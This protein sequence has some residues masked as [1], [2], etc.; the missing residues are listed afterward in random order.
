MDAIDFFNSDEA[1]LPRSRNTDDF[2]GF[3]DGMVQ[4]YVARMAGLQSADYVTQQIA[5][6]QPAVTALRFPLVEWGWG[7][8]EC[9][10]AIRAASTARRRRRARSSTSRPAT[11]TFSSVPWTSRATRGRT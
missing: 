4:A 11:Q 8:E 2:E 9:V 3:L 7:R 1:D 10:E 6:N 5:A